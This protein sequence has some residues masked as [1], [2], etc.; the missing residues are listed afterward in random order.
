M[1]LRRVNVIKDVL[2]A[3]LQLEAVDFHVTE[4]MGTE[5]EMKE[6]DMRSWPC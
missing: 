4:E 1:G 2:F 5:P 6:I 3:Y